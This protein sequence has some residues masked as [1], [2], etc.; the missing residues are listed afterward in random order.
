MG[1]VYVVHCID[2]EGPLYEAPLVPF[3]QIKK[4]FGVEIEPTREN[5][6]KLQNGQIPLGGQEE[7]IKNLV[8]SHKL[9]TKGTWE[10]IES[11]INFI[12]KPEY[13]NMLIDSKGEGWKYSWFCMDH[14]GF[15][16]NNPRRRDAG[17]HK[18]FD[19]YMAL[20]KRQNLGDIVQFHHH[21][22]SISGNYNDSGTAFWGSSNLNDILT[23]KIIDREWFPVAFRPGFHTERP[24]SH[25]FLEQWIPFDYGNQSYEKTITGQADLD[26]GR[27]GDWRHAPLEWKPYHPDYTDY[28][29]QGTCKRWITRCLNMHARIREINLQEVERAFKAAQTQDVILAFTDHDYKDMIFEINKVRDMIGKIS[30]QYPG[31]QFEYCDAVNAM[32]KCLNLPDIGLELEAKIIKKDNY[33][34]LA[35]YAS[36]DI[37]GVQPYLA[38]KS[39]ASNYYWDNFDFT[40]KNFWTYT[41]DNNTISL[42]D[43][44]IIGIAANNIYGNTKVIKL[45]I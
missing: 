31:V 24:D 41:F 34:K 40:D 5:L 25:W 7:E 15:T 3:E 6:I 26:N 29:R 39:K 33:Y 36:N 44:D 14:V 28:Q 19:R 22:V 21:P 42:N 16:G 1:T 13:R 32:K 18:V 27:F 11:V 37:F 10:E 30:K 20:V 12:T 38:I 23:R 45:Q 8:D 2:T 43:V 4:I 17:H 9:S 35:V